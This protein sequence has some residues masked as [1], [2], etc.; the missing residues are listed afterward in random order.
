M[1][2]GIASAIMFTTYLVFFMI[3]A[4][5][6]MP[7]YSYFFI[8]YS[9]FV[10][11]KNHK[12]A[13]IIN[14]IFYYYILFLNQNYKKIC[15]LLDIHLV[16]VCIT[17][18]VRF[19]IIY[20]FFQQQSVSFFLLFT[21][22]I[23]CLNSIFRVFL[24]IG[25]MISNKLSLDQKNYIVHVWG[26]IPQNNN[27]SSFIFESNN[28]ATR[29]QETTYRLARNNFYIAL[30]GLGFTFILTVCA[31]SNVYMINNANL[32]AEKNAKNIDRY[33]T[34]QSKILDCVK[35]ALENEQIQLK[36]NAISTTSSVKELQKSIT[37]IAQEHSEGPGK[38]TL[39]QKIDELKKK[40]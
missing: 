14:N 1:D 29:L 32:I 24:I 9:S 20:S 15:I 11:D 3:F 37:A 30:L 22:I 5:F 19:L 34:L 8:N 18:L 13:K 12:F 10:Y 33:L 2:Y 7:I 4:S 31:V 28:N 21:Y 23:L 35:I 17:H 16:I 39:M 36:N 6:I 26:K 38:T 25:Q 27:S 40:N